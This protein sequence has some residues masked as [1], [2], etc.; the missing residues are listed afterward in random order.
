MTIALIIVLGAGS[1]Q[2]VRLAAERTI[3]FQGETSR[4]P[5]LGAWH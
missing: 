5:L 1:P 3:L 2:D 4:T